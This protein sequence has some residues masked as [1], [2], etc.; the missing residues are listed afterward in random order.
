MTNYLRDEIVIFP[1]SEASNMAWVFRDCYFEEFFMDR[2]PK[3]RHN[4]ST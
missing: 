1:L 2:Y 3:T 4:N